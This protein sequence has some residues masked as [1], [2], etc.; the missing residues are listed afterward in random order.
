M[1]QKCSFLL[2][3]MKQISTSF[4]IKLIL[5]LIL[6]KMPIISKYLHCNIEKIGLISML[7]IPFLPLFP[8]Q[9]SGEVC[10]MVWFNKTT[11]GSVLPKAFGESDFVFFSLLLENYAF[12]HE[13]GLNKLHNE[14]TCY[15]WLLLKSVYENSSR[16]FFLHL[17]LLQESEYISDFWLLFRSI[18]T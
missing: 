7:L 10:G 1:S 3:P 4:F 11:K 9:Y 2:I 16:I 18:Y 12:E 15:A 8:A 6:F 14:R 5:F 17:F 13:M